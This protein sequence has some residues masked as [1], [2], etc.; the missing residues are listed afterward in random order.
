MVFFQPNHFTHIILV[1][2]ILLQKKFKSIFSLHW[3]SLYNLN[4]T[5]EIIEDGNKN[6]S[7]CFE[8]WIPK[9]FS[10]KVFMI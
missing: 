6:K 8:F 1:E 5:H 7:E 2:N 3:L 10:T 9:L 4:I